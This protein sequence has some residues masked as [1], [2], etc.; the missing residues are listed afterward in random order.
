MKKVCYLR[1]V[2][3]IF[4]ICLSP[5]EDSKLFLLLTYAGAGVQAEAIARVRARARARAKAEARTG[6]RAGAGAR[7][8]AW[9]PERSEIDQILNFSKNIEI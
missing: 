1:T 5:Y 9:T 8:R 7:A 4:S 2:T 3:G 6:A